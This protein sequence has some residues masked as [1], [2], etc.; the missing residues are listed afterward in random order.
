MIEIVTSDTVYVFESEADADGWALE[1]SP[2]PRA[3]REPSAAERELA[4]TA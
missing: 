2:E 4:A 3:W 1:G